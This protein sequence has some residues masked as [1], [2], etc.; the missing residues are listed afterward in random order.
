MHL[1]STFSSKLLRLI[2]F[3]AYDYQKQDFL[4]VLRDIRSLIPQNHKLLDIGCYEGDETLDYARILDT[5]PG[6]IFG[7]YKKFWDVPIF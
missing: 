5:Q 7:T 1:N 2:R 6:N 3:N 4:H